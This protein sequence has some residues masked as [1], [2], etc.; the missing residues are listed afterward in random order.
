MDQII[1]FYFPDEKISW[2]KWASSQPNNAG[3]GEHFAFLV[4]KNYSGDQSWFHDNQNSW[5]DDSVQESENNPR[6]LS[7]ICVKK[8]I[9]GNSGT[10]QDIDES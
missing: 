1:N 5:R 3:D 7:V 9:N 4:P 8:E 10:C 6:P 2:N